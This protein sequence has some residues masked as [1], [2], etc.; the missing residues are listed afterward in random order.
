MS[1]EK[2]FQVQ[3]SANAGTHRYVAADKDSVMVDA[4]SKPKNSSPAGMINKPV[5]SSRGE[6]RRELNDAPESQI[7][8]SSVVAQ[9]ARMSFALFVET[10]FVPE[11][12]QYKTPAGQTH[13][14][15]MLKHLIT[16]EAVSAIFKS[17]KGAH[18]RLSALPGWPYLDEL[19][20][21]DLRP[22]HIRRVVAAADDAGYSPQTVKHIKNVCFAIVAHAQKEG[23]F[24]GPNPASLVKLPRVTRSTSPPLSSQQL[25]SILEALEYPH[26]EA[27]LFALTT[28][29]NLPDICDL[30]WKNV[31]LEEFASLADG[32]PLPGR[33]LLVKGWWNRAGLGDSRACGKNKILEIREPLLS[34]LR[35]LRENKPLA[36]PD[37][38]VLASRMG[39][40]LIPASFW[41]SE[42]KRVAKVAGISK[43][44]WQDLRRTHHVFPAGF[45]VP[46]PRA[47]SFGAGSL[48]L[49]RPSAE[50][51]SRQQVL[52]NDSFSGD[53]DVRR[54]SCFGRRLRL[55]PALDVKLDCQGEIG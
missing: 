32:H 33:S 46:T 25:K 34:A 3:S 8:F 27:A 16:P 23:C 54:T 2:R 13:Y 14:Q 51:S 52:C 42:M 45:L 15:A 1:D 10:K 31:N 17:E 30:R 55:S 41:V 29:M 28:G 35:G 24:N 9:D 18:A 37:D 43:L 5:I 21:C 6:A 50:A 40:R 20:L 39:D 36:D 4:N 48:C 44:T 49:H 12:V 38:L 19:R 53:S 26:R 47:I 7:I 22:E 11:H